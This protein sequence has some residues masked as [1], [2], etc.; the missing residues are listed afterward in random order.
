LNRKI[1]QQVLSILTITLK[2]N[3]HTGGCNE[4]PDCKQI[5]LVMDNLNTHTIASLYEAFPPK[6]ARSLAKRLEIHFTPKNGSWLNIAEIELS[7][8]TKQCLDRRIDNITSLKI[9]L[10]A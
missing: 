7:A 9:E 8:M 5:L 3:R 2:I 1:I 10:T 4:Y 6:T